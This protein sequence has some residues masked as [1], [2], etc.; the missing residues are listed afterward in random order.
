MYKMNTAKIKISLILANKSMIN[1]FSSWYKIYM[2]YGKLHVIFC[3]IP[4]IASWHHLKSRIAFLCKY[5][6]W[7]FL[8]HSLHVFPYG[9]CISLVSLN[10]I[11]HI[12][13]ICK[14]YWI[15]CLNISFHG[16][17]CFYFAIK[18]LKLNLM[19]AL[20]RYS[21]DLALIYPFKIL[22]VLISAK[23]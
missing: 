19:S 15:H 12:K 9:F 14:G 13:N 4:D 18:C 20:I 16:N 10:A 21:L 8:W 1:I 7:S 17:I 11:C 6:C 22:P 23:I 2:N 3:N 5:V